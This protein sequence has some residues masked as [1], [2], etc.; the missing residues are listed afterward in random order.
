MKPKLICRITPLIGMGLSF[1]PSLSGTSA[2]FSGDEDL[3]NKIL[4]SEPY[5]SGIAEYADFKTAYFD[6]LTYNFGANYKGSCGYVAIGMLLSY[7]DTYLDDSI[8]TEAYDAPFIGYGS[9]TVE[10]R[11][12]LGV[13]KDFVCDPDEIQGPKYGF[14]L[15]SQEYFSAISSR[16]ILRF[17][18][19]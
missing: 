5:S 8:I 12:S 2:R 15:N 18:Q 16:P 17:T 7:Y 19:G 10:R 11:N 3:Q 6:N 9:D 14:S 4:S 1:C 13:Q